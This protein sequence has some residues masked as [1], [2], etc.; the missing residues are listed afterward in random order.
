MKSRSAAGTA[1]GGETFPDRRGDFPSLLRRHNGFP[2]A[3]LDGPAGTQ[4]PGPVIDAMTRYYT[5]SNANTH[6][7]FLTSEESDRLL[8]AARDLAAEFLG[9]PGARCIS[10]GANMTT[11]NYALA[12][13]IGRLLREGD[14][15][16][17]TQLDHEA[18]RGPWLGLREKG[19]VV[20][21]IVLR[22]DATLD[23][24]DFALKVGARTRL[25]AMGL[26]SNAF[27]TV[28]DVA[29]A[30]TVTKKAGAMLLVDAVHYAPHFP[31]DA[32]AM[33]VD[34]LL[35][36]AYKFYGPHVGIL[37]AR[38]GLLESI[39]TDRLRTQDQHAPYRIETGT[40]N[41]AAI[42][43][44]HA[45]I[46][47]IASF[48]A[49]ADRR[50]RIVRGME[51]IGAHE[52]AL[53][54]ELYEGLSGIGGVTVCGPPFGAAR[55]APTVSF[56][57]DGMTPAEVCTALGRRGICAWDGDFY[58]V[59]PMEVLGLRERGGVTRAGISLYNNGEEVSRFV[60]EVKLLA[61]GR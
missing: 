18:N 44:V 2:L 3:F 49:G 19:V 40:L 61:R 15:I 9:A 51:R 38:E 5:T 54:R 31:V 26:A 59:R 14:E 13:G 28:N 42:A 11:L 6:G 27:G 60:D 10:F 45:A 48:G 17:I 47:Y 30:G 46:E 36:S 25:V 1:S 39:E 7:R 16:L 32:L 33:G 21:E 8:G 24:D 58:A 57:L 4:V 52:N 43:G 56:T 22:P 55:R 12:R 41:H 50:S 34:F 37:Y 20:T 23:Y 29:F 35:C 53:A